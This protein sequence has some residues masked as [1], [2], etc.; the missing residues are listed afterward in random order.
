MF[1]NNYGYQQPFGNGYQMYQT[2]QQPVT[3]NN[4]LTKE[5]LD[6]LQQKGDKLTITVTPLEIAKAI[7]TH[8]RGNMI[9]LYN[10]DPV[11]PER[12]KCGICGEEFDLT[13]GDQAAVEGAVDLIVNIIQT[14]KTYWLDVPDA[15]AREL[16]PIIPL[17]QKLPKVY[18]IASKNFSAVH[19]IHQMAEQQQPFGFGMFNNIMNPMMGMGYGYP[20]QPMMPQQSNVPYGQ[21]NNAF[22]S[23]NAQM[24]AQ[25]PMMPQQMPAQPPMMQAPM[26]YVPQPMSNPYA[27]NPVMM[28]NMGYQAPTYQDPASQGINPFGYGA[29]ATPAAPQ[30]PQQPAAPAAPQQPPVAANGVPAPAAE[31]VN[32][33]MFSV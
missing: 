10:E 8:K 18:S 15:V 3:L 2:Q 17:I 24:Q 29:P 32:E 19:D 23:F 26:G 16:Y 5:Q 22:A 20:Q 11:N 4:P 13:N 28:P 31:A 25:Q 30:T 14:I 12:V 27:M 33:K 7:C 9:C 1:N 21:N 6:L